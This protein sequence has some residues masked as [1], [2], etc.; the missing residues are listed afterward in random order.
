LPGSNKSQSTESTWPSSLSARLSAFVSAA[1]C[2]R[3]I[4]VITV[5]L[6]ESN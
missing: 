2:D 5:L 1:Q 3:F 4:A 6:R